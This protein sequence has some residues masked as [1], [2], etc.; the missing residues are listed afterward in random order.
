[1][2]MTSHPDPELVFFTY[3]ELEDGG[4]ALSVKKS[5]SLYERTPREAEFFNDLLIHP[6]GQ[7]A[8]ASCYAGKLKI[9]KLK[10]G[11][12]AEDFDLPYVH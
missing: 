7:L 11:E 2:L 10:A 6:S 4:A 12:Y 3:D 9:I 8:V 5:L 1:M